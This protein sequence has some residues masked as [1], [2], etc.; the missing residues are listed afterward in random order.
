MAET[1]FKQ[2]TMSA[3]SKTLGTQISPRWP[4]QSI[5]VHYCDHGCDTSDAGR[6]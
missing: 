6:I 4:D 1:V 5:S 3:Y 2:L